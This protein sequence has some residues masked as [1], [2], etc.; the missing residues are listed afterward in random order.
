M[1]QIGPPVIPIPI[2]PVPQEH[3]TREVIFQAAAHLFSRKGYAATSVR[4][5]VQA[6]GVTKPALYYYFKNKEDLYVQLMEDA[7]ETL[8]QILSAIIE[9]QGSMRRRLNVFFVSV[10]ELFREYVDFVR[11]VNMCIHGP[12]DALPPIDFDSAQLRLDALLRQ[13]VEP[14]IAEGDLATADMDQALFML[15]SVFRSIQAIIVVQPPG[16]TINPEIIARSI[17]CIFDGL[18]S[19]GESRAAQ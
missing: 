5:I 6:A 16:Q 2:P 17:D 19:S 15:L 9:Q 4:E 3:Q 10:S 18:K 1:S 12:R 14:G 7:L 13:L 8:W 11:L